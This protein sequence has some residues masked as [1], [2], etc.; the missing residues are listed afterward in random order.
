VPFP[1][2]PFT[3][4]RRPSSPPSQ[5]PSRTRYGYLGGLLS[6][7][8]Q[9]GESDWALTTDKSHLY[10]A[11]M[12]M[13]AT[14]Q[15]GAPLESCINSSLYTLQYKAA[16]SDADA[17]FATLTRGVVTVLDDSQRGVKLYPLN[18]EFK[19]SAGLLSVTAYFGLTL[20]DRSADN[21]ENERILVVHGPQ[22]AAIYDHASRLPIGSPLQELATMVQ[23]YAKR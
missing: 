20:R 22:T 17:V 7:Q 10:F 16:H 21:D 2:N 15:P 19:L 11:G 18:L 12:D 8:R 13:S 9:P 23:Q 3:F 14:L 4:A 6:S 5:S 1:K